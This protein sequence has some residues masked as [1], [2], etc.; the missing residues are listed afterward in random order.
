MQVENTYILLHQIIQE[1]V[2]QISSESPEFCRRYYKENIFSHIL[3][4]VSG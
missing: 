4:I 3:Y 1:T 2:C